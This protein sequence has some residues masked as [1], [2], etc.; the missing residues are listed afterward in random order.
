VVGAKF[1]LAGIVLAL[2]G[3][4]TAGADNPTVRIDPADQAKADAALLKLKDFGPG[5]T[6]GPRKP[7]KLAAPKCP[8][9]N[10]KESDLT[11]TGHAEARYTFPGQ[12]GFDQDV[13]VLKS[14]HA[15]ATDFGRVIGPKLAHCL[16]YQLKSSQHVVS[17]SV[18]RLRFPRIGDDT[19]AYRATVVVKVA[20]HKIKLVRDY[21]FLGKGRV[22]FSLA[23]EAPARLGNELQAFEQAIAHKLSESV[24]SNVA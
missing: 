15:V 16:A 2:V 7:E 10:P 11:V 21:V 20:G 23:F 5:W 14:G 19:A 6:G 9:F 18:T 12:V 8:G 13:Q 24:G 22:E 17:A 4:A 3:A 1:L